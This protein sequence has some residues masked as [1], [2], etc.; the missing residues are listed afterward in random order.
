MDTSNLL[1]PRTREKIPAIIFQLAIILF[2]AFVGW[3][4]VLN[5]QSNLDRLGISAGFSFLSTEAGF[6]ISQKLIDFDAGASYFKAMAAAYLNTIVLSVFGILLC[7]V[8]GLIVA[9]LRFAINPVIRFVAELYVETFRNIPL[10]LQIFFWYF[11]VIA[12]LPGVKNSYALGPFYLNN[13]GL[14]LPAYEF[15]AWG[16]LVFSAGLLGVVSAVII[17]VRYKS[18]YGRIKLTIWRLAGVF[19]IIP[20]VL[21]LVD[22]RLGDWD[23]P[24]LAGFNYRGGVAIRPEFVA[25]LAGL[26]I[27]NS[28]FMS[29]IFRSGILSVSRG[30]REAA[31]T[32]GLS[33]FK[34]NLLIILP[35][36]L[37]VA[38]PP[39]GGQLQIVIKASS[40]SAAIAYPDVMSVIGGTIITQTSQAIECMVIVMGLFLTTNLTLTFLLNIYNNYI[41]RR[42]GR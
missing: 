11:G 12:A 19:I 28:T 10:L 40:L 2:L 32:V 14:F 35:Q 41:M 18:A 25:M 34:V 39:A 42:G 13:R 21:Y 31:E 15:T 3:Q 1:S 4:I 30:Q 37:R 33:G 17:L 20:V 7:S 27:Y 36:A 22:Y 8:L 6:D 26:S 24:V 9:F 23:Y 38:I 29:E 16:W 5:A